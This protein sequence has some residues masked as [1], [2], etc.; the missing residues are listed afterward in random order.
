MIEQAGNQ[1]GL[2]GCQAGS[3]DRL[4]PKSTAAGGLIVR[5][6]SADIYETVI[7]QTESLVQRNEVTVFITFRILAHLHPQL[8]AVCCIP[9]DEIEHAGDGIRPIQR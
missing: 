6:F 1:G 2:S 7:A 8:A 3:T 9:E 5:Q 4:I